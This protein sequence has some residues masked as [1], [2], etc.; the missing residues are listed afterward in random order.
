[1]TTPQLSTRILMTKIKK[2]EKKQ[3]E[4]YP[5]LL[6]KLKKIF[7]RLD[8]LEQSVVALV[9]RLNEVNRELSNAV[10]VLENK[11]N[12]EMYNIQYPT[13]KEKE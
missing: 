7:L 12:A 1:M 8:R 9:N 4:R 11:Q 3:A 10:R 5:S 6:E 13:K 2:I